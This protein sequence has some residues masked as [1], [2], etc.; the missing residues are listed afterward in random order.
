MVDVKQN[1]EWH[2][3]VEAYGIGRPKLFAGSIQRIV[4]DTLGYLATVNVQRGAN[5]REILIVIRDQPMS[6]EKEGNDMVSRAAM[7]ELAEGAEQFDGTAEEL[8]ALYDT[9]WTAD[10]VWKRFIWLQARQ[11]NYESSPEEYQTL[12]DHLESKY[13]DHFRTLKKRSR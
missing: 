8:M 12:W 11:S 13:P 5:G 10:P 2:G 6:D 1:T 4:A 3:R 7:A 9:P